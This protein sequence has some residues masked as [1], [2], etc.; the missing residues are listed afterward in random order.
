VIKIIAVPA[1]ITEHFVRDANG[2]LVPITQE[3]NKPIAET[4]LQKQTRQPFLSAS[5]PLPRE[6]PCLSKDNPCLFI[7]RASGPAHHHPSCGTQCDAAIANA[8]SVP[9]VKVVSAAVLGG[10]D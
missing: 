10:S 1:G 3:S 6:G 7:S 4:R 8:I 5:I 2:E 9:T